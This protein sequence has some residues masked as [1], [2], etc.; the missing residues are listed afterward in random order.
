[1]TLITSFER[2]HGT[3]KLHPTKLV[4]YVKVIES[5]SHPPIVQIDTLGSEEREKPNK[6]SQTIQMG[7]ESAHQ[8]FLILKE[9]YGF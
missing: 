2:K 6:Q 9:T 7:K 4:G 3:G 1:M 5:D 8:L